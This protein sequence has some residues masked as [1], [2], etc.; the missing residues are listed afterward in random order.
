MLNDLLKKRF[1][2][3][4]WNEMK[5]VPYELIEGIL[6][7]IYD[8]PR[9]GGDTNVMVKLL[10]PSVE[11]TRLKKELLKITWCRDGDK[12]AT[13]NTGP[14]R[15]QGQLTAPYVF[16]FGTKDKDTDNDRQ[17]N[18]IVQTTIAM[19]SA[20]EKGLNT[21]YCCCIEPDEV[22]ASPVNF[23]TLSCL[24]VGYAEE[25]EKRS[26]AY[27]ID[28]EEWIEVMP[29]VKHM[30]MSNVIQGYPYGDPSEREKP[31]MPDM[32]IVV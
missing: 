6:Q 3:R 29:G 32:S 24:G 31:P 11:G 19:I 26:T 10:T 2:T 21:G 8:S 25:P 9:K 7:D 4:E 17:I 5:K 15:L 22:L 30:D 18:S 13:E 27:T 12:G 1:T 14:I 23:Y 28:T 20:Q 16:L